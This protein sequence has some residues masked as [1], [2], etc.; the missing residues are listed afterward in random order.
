MSWLLHLDVEPAEAEVMSSRL[1]DLGTIGLA[2]L[3]EAKMVAG[4]ENE[5]EAVAACVALGQGIQ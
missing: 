4:F 1:W 5:A 3:P 2:E